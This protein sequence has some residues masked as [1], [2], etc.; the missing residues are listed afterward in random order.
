MTHHIS[1][2]HFLGESNSSL[3]EYK[4]E[5]FPQGLVQGQ[6][7][8]IDFKPPAK[9]YWNV[10]SDLVLPLILEDS[11]QQCEAKWAAR[12]QEEKS[13]R[14]KVYQTEVPTPGESP[15]LEAGGSGTALPTKT[16]P[17]RE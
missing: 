7:I 10:A 16:A 15:Q 14:V 2:P 17:N 13:N 8:A 9:D 11:R 4:S 3:I 12:A 1:F 5:K 6:K